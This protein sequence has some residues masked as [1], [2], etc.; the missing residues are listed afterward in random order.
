VLVA[1]RQTTQH[2][3]DTAALGEALL[4]AITTFPGLL[5]ADIETTDVAP[6]ASQREADVLAGLSPVLTEGATL[7]DRGAVTW[8][9]GPTPLALGSVTA[10]VKARLPWDLVDVPDGAPARLVDPLDRLP[11]DPVVA[12]LIRWRMFPQLA[13]LADGDP[14]PVVLDERQRKVI[15]QL[16]GRWSDGYQATSVAALR[17]LLADAVV[18]ADG[19]AGFAVRR[20]IEDRYHELRATE[21]GALDLLAWAAG[22]D[23]KMTLGRRLGILDAARQQIP[24]ELS[25]P[26]AT[27]LLSDTVRALNTLGKRSSHEL[28]AV[29]PALARQVTGELSPAGQP[30]DAADLRDAG[31]PAAPVTP[32]TT[33]FATWLVGLHPPGSRASIGAQVLGD[34]LGRAV[35]EH[36]PVTNRDGTPD[37]RVVNVKA[38]LLGTAQSLPNA[39]T[40]RRELFTIDRPPV[41]DRV[42]AEVSQV[43]TGCTPEESDELLEALI[44]AQVPDDA[45]AVMVVPTG[46]KAVVLPLV[47]A[48][49]RVAAMRGVPLFLRELSPP[50]DGSEAGT[51]LWPTLAEGDLPLLVAAREALAGLEMDVAWRLL[52]ATSVA[53]P[54]AAQ[55]RE[56][57][58]AITCRLPH[59]PAS[60]PAHLLSL[61]P[62]HAARTR[63]L[64]PERLRLV[65]ASL[66]TTGQPATRIRYLMLAASAVEVTVGNVDPSQDGRTAFEPFKDHLTTLAADTSPGP[67]PDA[68]AVFLVLDAARN[69]IPITHGQHA[70][71][72]AAVRVAVG[73]VA[74]HLRRPLPKLR[75]RLI[76][77][78]TLIDATVDA[79]RH[80]FAEAPG[81]EGALTRQHASL[82]TQ[83]SG[84]IGR[85]EALGG[86]ARKPGQ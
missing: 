54:L 79:A 81:S 68:A 53:D 8:A 25:R 11:I 26:S 78:P 20:Y 39:E 52:S 1:T 63:G 44:T 46:P 18:R 43:P 10:L 73:D 31:L 17:G 4:A 83:L 76:D 5:G 84:E 12:L 14:A 6:A 38:L 59:D 40:Q 9:S 24:A 16:A 50:S 30:V 2:P 36:L 55:C 48:A 65:R 33:V 67:T 62:D 37:E 86:T 66:G 57:T 42:T 3:L 77:V 56:L 82:L 28:T 49:R 70:D 51:H 27:W 75:H 69:H 22:P 71:P 19:T 72:D 41:L 35:R 29:T 58:N 15:H 64:L 13:A 74:R 85:R 21:P 7:T 61:T 34:A 47:R 60:W 32:G 23:A 45:A 80:L